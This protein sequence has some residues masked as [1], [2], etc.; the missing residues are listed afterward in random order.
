MTL[1]DLS[2]IAGT[3]LLSLGGGAVIVFVLSKWLGGVWA[4]RILE[5][6]RAE[7]AREHELLVRRRN[8]YTKLA[9]SM[10]VFLK[11]EKP[12]TQ[13]Q[14]DSFLAAYD[15]A[16][17]WAAEEVA[18]ELGRFIDML[19]KHTAKSGSVSNKDIQAEFVRCITV[20]RR[21]CGFS[22]KIKGTLPF[23]LVLTSK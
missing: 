3:V 13:E 19:I 4:G 9:L 8:V 1:T 21:D 10:R 5:N 15:E 14:K 23:I 17:L 22:K 12:G 18:D 7:L 2:Q 6:E 11:S 20:M 16:A